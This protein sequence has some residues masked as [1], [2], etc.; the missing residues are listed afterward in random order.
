MLGQLTP[1]QQASVYDLRRPVTDE[2]SD[3]AAIV[4]RAFA[5]QDT[6]LFAELAKATEAPLPWIPAAVARWLEETPEPITGLGKLA[7]LS[8]DAVRSGHDKPGDTFTTVAAADTP[9]QYCGDTTLW[10]KINDLAYRE[11]PLVQIDGPNNRLP[12]W[13]TDTPMNEYTV[14]AV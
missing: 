1:E 8:L 7:A 10:A 12:Q 4:D 13:I 11:P 5:T 6:A 14:T 9:P 2:Q 3:Y